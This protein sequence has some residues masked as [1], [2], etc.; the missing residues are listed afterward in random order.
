MRFYRNNFSDFSCFD[1]PLS[2]LETFIKSSHKSNLKLYIIFLSCVDHL[3]AFIFIHCHWF[4]TENMFSCIG[5]CYRNLFMEFCWTRYNHSINFFIFH[6]IVIIFIKKIDS[7]LLRCIFCD[8]SYRITN[9]N[10]LSSWN[11]SC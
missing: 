7:K 10:D 8:I 2:F 1:H 4:F 3:I 6:H 11:T 9:S 5:C